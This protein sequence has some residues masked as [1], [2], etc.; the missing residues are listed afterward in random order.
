MGKS[1]EDNEHAAWATVLGEVI[2]VIL[3]KGKL[4]SPDMGSKH[5]PLAKR[6]GV[7]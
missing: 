1:L 4:F 5:F 3:S 2:T 6:L 7:T